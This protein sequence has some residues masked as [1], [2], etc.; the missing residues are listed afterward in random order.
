V[1]TSYGIRLNDSAT[2]E[3]RQLL[4]PLIPKLVGTRGDR[5]L[6]LKR[7]Y[8]F[9]DRAVRLFAPIA[10]RSRGKIELVSEL[11]A[12]PP[13]VDESTARS[14]AKICRAAAAA[15]AAAYAAAASPA[16]SSAASSAASGQR[17]REVFLKA[18]EVF[19]QA[20][21]IGQEKAAPAQ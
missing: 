3:D 13:I 16:S 8:F 4:K 15:Y 11:E 10:L 7:A 17:R 1:L 14:A 9:A 12:L 6:E 19:E 5:A 21:A 20:I 18:V 2:N